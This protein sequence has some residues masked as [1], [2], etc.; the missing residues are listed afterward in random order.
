MVSRNNN[1]KS[2]VE[3]TR[4]S[5]RI[6]MRLKSSK[7]AASVSKVTKVTSK[8]ISKANGVT[9]KTTTQTTAST[10]SK[11][12]SVKAKA[13]SKSKKN[14]G[15]ATEEGDDG[16]D[17]EGGETGTPKPQVPKYDPSPVEPTILNLPTIT[18]GEE[19]VH[20]GITHL[21]TTNPSLSTIITR[22]PCTLFSASGLLEPVNPFHSLCS[23]II[24]Q[25]VSSAAAAS[26]KSRFIALFNTTNTFPKPSEILT[27]DIDTLRTAGLSQRKAEYITGLA[28]LFVSGDLTNEL[29]LESSDETVT[30]RLIKVRGLGLW[31]IQMFLLFALKR[32]DVFATGDLGIQRGM[33]ILAGRDVNKLKFSKPGKAGKWKYMAEDEMIKLAEVYSPYRSVLSWYLWRLADTDVEVL[34]GV[35]KTKVE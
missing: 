33:A 24:S 20:P 22:H 29:L 6:S 8:T 27:K 32:T 15:P 11:K 34:K 9:K 10:A 3:A 35:D 19:E 31:S 28:E 7:S 5:A 13:S 4:V 16:N 23:G 21:L 14:T 30:E 12:V 26:I 1:K 18:T 17:G 2:T 25:Q